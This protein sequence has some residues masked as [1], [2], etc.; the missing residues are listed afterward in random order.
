MKKCLECEEVK[1]FSEFNRGGFSEDGYQNECRVCTRKANA[2]WNKKNSKKITAS[3]RKK[4]TGYTQKEYDIKF[5][6]QKGCCAICGKNQ[7]KLKRALAADHC[8][9]TGAKR[10][11][12]CFNC[13]TALGKFNDSVALLE[14]AIKYLTGELKC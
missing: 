9:T 7:S 10:G 13:N 8:H 3:I 6:E 11:L 4:R 1:E 14:K 5:N 12:L 2:I